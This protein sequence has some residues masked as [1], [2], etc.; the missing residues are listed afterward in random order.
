MIGFI[1]VKQRCTHHNEYP[2]QRFLLS[3]DRICTFN[4]PVLYLGHESSHEWNGHIK[5]TNPIVRKQKSLQW[6]LI[7]MCAML[8]DPNQPNH[9]FTASPVRAREHQIRAPEKGILGGTGRAPT[10]IMLPFIR[11]TD[12]LQVQILSCD[13][14][15]H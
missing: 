11:T 14:S 9:C 7:M 2:L 12:T 1:R 6:V 3:Y 15:C 10:R 13:M 5:S 4:V 8:L